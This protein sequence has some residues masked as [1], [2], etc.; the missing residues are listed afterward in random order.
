MFK[1]IIKFMKLFFLSFA[2]L[3]SVSIFGQVHRDSTER[4]MSLTMPESKWNDLFFWIQG[5]GKNVGSDCL[6]YIKMLGDHLVV[7]VP[8]SAKKDSVKSKPKKPK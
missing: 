1:H 8:E 7:V 6:D 4:L 2:L 5:S 3:V